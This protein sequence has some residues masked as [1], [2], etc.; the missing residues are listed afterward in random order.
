[1]GVSTKG[2]TTQA[3]ASTSP[4]KAL[5]AWLAGLLQVAVL[6]LENFIEWLGQEPERNWEVALF[7]RGLSVRPPSTDALVR[8]ARRYADR[9]EAERALRLYIRVLE[10]DPDRTDV[11][12][13]AA[14][15]LAE[16]GDVD[17]AKDL[18]LR[19]VEL[20]PDK[21][22]GKYV[23]LGHL[24]HGSRAVEC[25]QKG[26]ELLKAEETSMKSA[27]EAETKK[28]GGDA[29][30][31]D[32]KA[33]LAMTALRKQ[34]SS[35]LCAIA[36][37]FL[38]D[39]FMEDNS[40]AHCEELLDQALTYDPD[41][42]EACQ[43]LADL[44][45]TQD[46]RGESLLLIRR[47]VE[48]CHH[49]PDGLA[50]SY[51]FRTVT[52]RLLVEL[53]QYDTAVSILKELTAEDAEDAEVLFL[54]G[55][56]H[57]LSGRPGECA[58]VLGTAKELLA[59]RG[60]GEEMQL[61]R[62]IDALLARRSV[63]EDEKRAFWNPRWWVEVRS[64][65]GSEPEGGAASVANGHEH[66]QEGGS[67]DGGAGNG[68][69]SGGGGGDGGAR[70]KDW[71]YGVDGGPRLDGDSPPMSTMNPMSGVHYS[72]TDVPGGR[73]D[74]GGVAKGGNARVGDGHGLESGKTPGPF[75]T[76]LP[77]AVAR[78]KTPGNVYGGGDGFEDLPV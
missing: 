24:E 78:G 14:E 10:T 69:G 3:T 2:G 40:L 48:V 47:T 64:T 46:R 19:S 21:G 58:R 65:P 16:L 32:P 77:G 20:S 42:P 43:A 17:G 72:G 25:F 45:L 11:L 37:V 60:A 39:C 52:A 49:L 4:V 61:V 75:K 9:G 56:C 15:L 31:P 59:A 18:L 28:G 36:K 13:A 6:V 38:T 73:V 67:V 1:M 35:V 62:Q 27:V 8:H 5:A 54:L 29:A 7:M 41:N 50:P 57:I 12:D 53:S 76:R 55:I 70:D 23:L 26:Y 63:T 22:C 74:S 30:A 68:G 44:R 33:T 66:G 34:I 51:D 71:H